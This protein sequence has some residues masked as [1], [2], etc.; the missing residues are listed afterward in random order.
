MKIKCTCIPTS[1]PEP[2][3]VKTGNE[4]NVVQIFRAPCSSTAIEARKRNSAP[5]K[6]SGTAEVTKL[7]AVSTLDH[8]LLSV[9]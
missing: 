1:F 5:F 4:I 3:L 9:N 7:I 8:E 6:T 2:V